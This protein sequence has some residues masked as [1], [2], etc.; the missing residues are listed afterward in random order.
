[1]NRVIAA[2]A[3]AL[4]AGAAVAQQDPEL[5]RL[6]QRIEELE[7][8]MDDADRRAYRAEQ[9][10]DNLKKE[11]EGLDAYLDI[12][13][14]ARR[15][16]TIQAQTEELRGISTELRFRPV[17][18]NDAEMENYFAAEYSREQKLLR[19]RHDQRALEIL[20]Y[21]PV[22]YRYDESIRR[23]TV[24]GL[25]GFYEPSDKTLYIVEAFDPFS[26]KGGEIIA[27]EI[28]HALQDIAYNLEE[29]VDFEGP[30]DYVQARR[31]IVEGDASVLD[32]EWVA[33]HGMGEPPMNTHKLRRLRSY[34]P[35]MEG[36]EEVSPALGIGGGSPYHV[37]A[38]F[39]QLMKEKLGEGWRDH[40]F[41]NPPASMEQVFHPEKYHGPGRE[42]PIAVS[43][44]EPPREWNVEVIHRNIEGELG[45]RLFLTLPGTIPE[46]SPPGMEYDRTDDVS[47]SAA[48]G[49]G[50]DSR[51][52]FQMLDED[53]PR[54][55]FGHLWKTV[56]D[57]ELD[58]TEFEAVLRDRMSVFPAFK[59]QAEQITSTRI[60]DG[61]EPVQFTGDGELLWF[62][63]RGLE[64]SMCHA[65]NEE[66]LARAVELLDMAVE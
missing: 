45:T 49:W 21:I 28:C 50:G 6:R 58:A 55:P 65:A 15:V 3:G 30:Y 14:W 54:P 12:A 44:A 11:L 35:P 25:A 17:V 20:T 8:Q 61:A 41:R 2:I 51:V 52:I 16:D 5:Q 48:I 22:G 34:L 19:T 38:V 7:R 63:R 37:G 4:I 13:R 47:V 66:M 39:C 40:I 53:D 46:I 36:E 10:Y 1:M 43:I 24:R 60:E 56:W 27:H 18:L 57:T 23:G 9:R 59:A 64:V 26:Q 32:Q 62:R 31:C 29:F 33:K 42:E